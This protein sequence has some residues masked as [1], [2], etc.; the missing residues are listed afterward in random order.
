[1][2]YINNLILNETYLNVKKM[3]YKI[4]LSI[5]TNTYDYRRKRTHK[6]YITA[7]RAS[8][9]DSV[10]KIVLKNRKLIILISGI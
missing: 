4:I 10:T 5:L 8:P 3:N 1:M 7:V 2:L 6:K 9:I